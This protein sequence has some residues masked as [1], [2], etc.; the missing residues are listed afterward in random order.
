MYVF[1][2][3]CR[4][5]F[6]SLCRNADCFIKHT[7]ILLYV[8]DQGRDPPADDESTEPMSSRISHLNSLLVRFFCSEAIPFETVE[9]DSFRYNEQTLRISAR[10]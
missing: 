10:F 6:E 4:N 5:V 8:C 7:T 9:S 2:S 1:E 3:L